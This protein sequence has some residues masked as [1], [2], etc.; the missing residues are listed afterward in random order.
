MSLSKKLVNGQVPANN[1]KGASEEPILY[2]RGNITITESAIRLG[3]YY[4]PV[5]SKTVYFKDIEKVEEKDYCKTTIYMK[6][7]GMAMDFRV[8]WHFD[9][10]MR[11]CD[12]DRRRAVI[13][14]IKGAS[15]FPGITPHKEDFERVRDL[16][17]ERVVA[18]GVPT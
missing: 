12:F 7:W 18:V 11:E 14:H 9:R 1:D 4:F 15:V 13:L 10:C 16:I 5:G 6:T 2:R 3:C 17:K 8:W